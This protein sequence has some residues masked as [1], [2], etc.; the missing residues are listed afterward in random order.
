MFSTSPKPGTVDFDVGPLFY[1]TYKVVGI[2]R[3]SPTSLTCLHIIASQ[4]KRCRASAR[5]LVCFIV[6]VFGN[7][8]RASARACLLRILV[9]VI[10]DLLDRLPAAP[11]CGGNVHYSAAPPRGV[12]NHKGSR[13]RVSHKIKRRVICRFYYR[14]LAFRYSSDVSKKDVCCKHSYSKTQLYL[15]FDRHTYR[16]SLRGKVRFERRDVLPDQNR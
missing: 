5:T 15:R 2:L 1:T 12:G 11:T 13:R 8:C 16:P 4:S 10:R 7:R 9:R 3:K 14:N 6:T